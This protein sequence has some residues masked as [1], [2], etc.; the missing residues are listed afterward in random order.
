M[1][2]L[3]IR[4]AEALAGGYFGG[5]F[6]WAA[7]C[8]VCGDRWGWLFALNTF[9]VYLFVPLLVMPAP[10]ALVRRRWVWTAWAAGLALGLYLYGGAFLPRAPTALA[11]RTPLT[12]MTYNMLGWNEDVAAVLATVR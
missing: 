3:G 1:R 11:G 8:F 4:R 10:A 6:G 2:A 5:L 9:A 7:L 12:V